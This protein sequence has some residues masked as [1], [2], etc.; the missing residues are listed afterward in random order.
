M[1][2][3][4]GRGGDEVSRSPDAARDALEQAISGALARAAGVA[5]EDVRVRIEGVRAEDV[6]LPF[7]VLHE[8]DPGAGSARGGEVEAGR[9]EAEPAEHEPA[10]SG[11]SEPDVADAPDVADPPDGPIDLDAQAEAAADFLEGLLDAFDLDGDLQLRVLADRAEVEITDAGEGVLIG[12][13]GQTLE[14]IQELTRSAL[15]RRFQQRAQVVVDVDG[16]RARRIERLLERTDEAIDEVRE[17][18]EAQRLEPMDAFERKVVHQRVAEAG[19]LV[20]NSFG[21]EPGRRVIIE[22]A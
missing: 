20:S 18:G 15:Q 5:P 4:F 9:A 10:E 17:T 8:G 21:R 12:R 16:Y 11:M 2:P 6:E 7:E 3:R 1:S 13:R 14:A 19:G 22:P